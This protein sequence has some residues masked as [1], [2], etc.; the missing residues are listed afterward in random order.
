MW[1]CSN[2]KNENSDRES[3]CLFCGSSRAEQMHP[4][5]FLEGV[6]RR[7]RGEKSIDLMDIT[8]EP[9]PFSE[10]KKNRKKQVTYTETEVLTA[11]RAVEETEDSWEA[12]VVLK[13]PGEEGYEEQQAEIEKERLAMEEA[14][15]KKEGQSTDRKAETGTMTPER[16]APAPEPKKDEEAPFVR[17][18]APVIPPDLTLEDLKEPKSKKPVVIAI[19]ALLVI[20]VVLFI[21]LRN[22]GDKEEGKK[23]ASASTAATTQAATQA[24]TEATTQEAT[25]EVVTEAK[26]EGWVEAEGKTY[27]YKEDGTPMIGWMEN[28]D[29]W[30]YFDT[31]GSLKTG[32]FTVEGSKYHSDERGILNTGLAEVDGKTYFFGENGAMKT[33]WK[34]VNDIYYYFRAD[35]TMVTEEWVEGFWLDKSGKQTYENKAEFKEDEKGKYFED[36]S[37]WFAHNTTLVIDG[38]KYTFD[39]KGY[40]VNQN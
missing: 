35:G 18:V 34:H 32:W 40:V 22:S 37:G 8:S 2:C 26:K 21:V 25:T 5:E 14:Q 13:Q 38:K 7:K 9:A 15:E 3:V 17:P 24:P 31:D 12:T 29:V 4:D 6:G 1:I 39:K 23:T 20:G 27:F 19:A 28:S 16:T 30:Y 10:K 11:E 36:E 33:G